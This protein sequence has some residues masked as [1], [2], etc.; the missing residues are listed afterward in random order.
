MFV[1]LFVCLVLSNRKYAPPPLSPNVSNLI[2]GERSIG[3][4][5]ASQ[6]LKKIAVPYL[7]HVKD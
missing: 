7:W 6:D 2:T 1:I 3:L 5:V 4:N